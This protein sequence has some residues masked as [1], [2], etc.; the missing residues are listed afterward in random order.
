M[1]DCPAC[2]MGKPC[3]KNKDGVAQSGKRF[4]SELPSKLP[5]RY[6]LFDKRHWRKPGRKAIDKTKIKKKQKTNWKKTRVQLKQV[7]VKRSKLKNQA[8]TAY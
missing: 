5:T 4:V 6:T 1:G 8:I 3:P 2:K 7:K